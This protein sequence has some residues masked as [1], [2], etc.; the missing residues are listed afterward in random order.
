[1]I[2][3]GNIALP[4]VAA[5]AARTLSA[6]NANGA[7][8]ASPLTGVVKVVRNASGTVSL[9]CSVA[10]FEANGGVVGKIAVV[11]RGTCARVA[12]AV[13]SGYLNPH[14]RIID[15]FHATNWRWRLI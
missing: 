1:M 10:A 2:D 13:Y 14:V 11:N 9:G 7:T 12:K 6:I 8:Y 15:Q 3:F 4:A 5:D